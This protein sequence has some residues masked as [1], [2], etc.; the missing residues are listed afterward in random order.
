MYQKF[1]SRAI[2]KQIIFVNTVY[3]IVI[4]LIKLPPHSG[5]VCYHDIH[6]FID[7]EQSLFRALPFSFSRSS[8]CPDFAR[9]FFSSQFCCCLMLDELSGERGL[10]VLC[11]YRRH[12][13]IGIS[14]L[15]CF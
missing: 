14:A 9:L 13:K 8:W 15:L 5:K 2:S 4:L 10:F 7:Y 6:V 1:L 12:K 11:V 3:T